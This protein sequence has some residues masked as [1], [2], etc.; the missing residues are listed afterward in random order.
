MKKVIFGG[1]ILASI[2]IG[3]VSCEKDSIKPESYQQKEAIQQENIY[4]NGKLLVFK[5][6]KDYESVVQMPTSEVEEDFLRK[7]RAMDHTT[8]S[9]FRKLSKSDVDLVED[10]FLAQI[11]NDDLAVQIGSWIYRVNKL[12]EKVYALAVKNAS[13]YSD[14][15]AENVLN[16]NV[17]EFTTEENVIELLESDIELLE[18]DIEFKTKAL[19]K[20][21]QSSQTSNDGGWQ[22]YSEWTD[23]NGIYGEVDKEYK[24]K[25]RMRVRYD[26]WG[27]YR[28]LFA[29]FKHK[30]AN[31]GTWDETYF[32]MQVYGSYLVRGG[33]SGEFELF[34]TYQIYGTPYMNSTNTN[35]YNF[36]D[37]KKEL[38]IY[39]GTRCLL[40]FELR[41]WAIFR[42]RE[43]RKPNL[44]P[45]HG[46]GVYI[47]GN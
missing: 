20:V 8:Y 12:S 33:G 14:L 4:S 13:D 17:L 26:N 38:Q 27:I 9:E 25:R 2:G 28:K 21:C 34:P 40:E 22:V 16:S 41:G 31:W 5:T 24:F 18:S 44:A 42:N 29:E 35:F 11:L 46:T 43:T 36:L 3:F 10:E 1:L 6:Y 7:V 37:D 19:L 47:I 30:E 23:E 32:S 15:I 39:R 45:N